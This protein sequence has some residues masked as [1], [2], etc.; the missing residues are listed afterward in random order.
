MSNGQR[1]KGEEGEI[2]KCEKWSARKVLGSYP[3][4]QTIT[5]ETVVSLLILNY[6]GDSHGGINGNEN[7]E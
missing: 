4:L 5:L 6:S 7:A 2:L 1:K 3:C